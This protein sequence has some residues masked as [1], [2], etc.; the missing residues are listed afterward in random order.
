MG[1]QCVRLTQSAYIWATWSTMSSE[2]PRLRWDSLI[3]S[4]LPPFAWM[5]WRTS[6]VMVQMRSITGLGN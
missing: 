2:R 4:G 6:R 1:G 5:K 3:S